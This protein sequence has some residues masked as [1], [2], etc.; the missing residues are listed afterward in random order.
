MGGDEAL[1]LFPRD[2]G[3]SGRRGRTDDQ[4]DSKIYLTWQAPITLMF[5]YKPLTIAPLQCSTVTIVCVASR[6]SDRGF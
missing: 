5:N 2:A 3:A 4:H 6:M 1:G